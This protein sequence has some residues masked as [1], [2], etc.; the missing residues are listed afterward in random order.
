VTAA[1]RTARVKRCSRCTLTK[2]TDAFSSHPHTRDRLQS[3][4]RDCLADHQ[5]ERRA[6]D[7]VV[8]A[9]DR[10]QSAAY[11][12]AARVLRERHRAEFDELYGAEMA[13]RGLA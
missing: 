2:P 10:A 6:A 13:K 12:A 8:V 11:H 3:W 7:R 5:R 4:C 1:V 9:R